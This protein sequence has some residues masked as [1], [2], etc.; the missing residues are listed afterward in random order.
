MTDER[1]PEWKPPRLY[2]EPTPDEVELYGERLARVREAIKARIKGGWYLATGIAFTTG[3]AIS[4]S[5]WLISGDI[6]AINWAANMAVPFATNELSQAKVAKVLDQARDE[7]TALDMNTQDS[8]ERKKPIF[9]KPPPPEAIEKYGD[10]EAYTRAVFKARKFGSAMLTLL[11]IGTTGAL[12]SVV[13]YVNRGEL[14]PFDWIANFS[15]PIILNGLRGIRAKK[16]IDRTE[17]DVI[18][19]LPDTSQSTGQ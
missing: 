15:V 7:I 3:A 10:Q 1:S 6:K 5:D 12:N 19:L 14:K 8:P 13:D 2:Q 17:S 11:V 4:M 16:I 18:A 9:F